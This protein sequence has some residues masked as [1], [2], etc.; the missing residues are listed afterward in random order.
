VGAGGSGVP[1]HGAMGGA[2]AGVFATALR[3]RF[4]DLPIEDEGRLADPDVRARFLD[5]AA[6]RS[7]R[8]RV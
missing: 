2:G 1:V 4:P 8:H 6:A 3:A 7:R 5:R